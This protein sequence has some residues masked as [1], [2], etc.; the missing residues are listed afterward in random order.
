MSKAE[1][2]IPFGVDRTKRVVHISD[3]ARGRACDCTCP[4]CGAPLT[5]VKGSVRQHHFR[6][7][8]ELECEGAVESAI[9]RAA[10]QMLRERKQLNLPDYRIEAAFLDSQG[11]RHR[12]AEIVVPPGKLAVFDSVE[13]EV[14]LL[15]MR[16]DLLA[17]EGT[18][19]LI[20][21][22]RFRHPVDDE[23]RAKIVAANISAIEIDLSDVSAEEA[24]WPTLWSRIND[25]AR[26]LWLYNAEEPKAFRERREPKEQRLQKAIQHMAEL[27]SPARIEEMRRQ[28]EHHQIWQEHKGFLAF[29]WNELP[30]FLN[31]PVPDGDWIY[32]CDRRLWQIAFY[33][34]FVCKRLT[35]FSVAR[36]DDWLQSMVGLNVPSCVKTVSRYHVTYRK[37]APAAR[38]D[39][40]PG[41][42]NTLDAYFR[43]LRE[44]GMLAPWES[45]SGVGG[46]RWYSVRITEPAAS[47]NQQGVKS[48][49]P[50]IVTAMA[51]SSKG[52]TARNPSQPPRWRLHRSRR[53]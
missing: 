21:E 30:T 20:I 51:E 31:V 40:L 38:K 12:A 49:A 16:A 27:S 22:I 15:G 45:H 17:I 39:F 13:E 9:H 33:N 24:D 8:V 2:R 34:H 29:A 46:D 14:S 53:L 41:P 52:G 10:K 5:A 36:V 44:A 50:V 26:I 11:E 37:M 28:A 6:H 35:P 3:A 25:P 4:G 1:I 7:T 32:G 47:A 23:K 43:V 42:R 19:Q 48:P 18:R